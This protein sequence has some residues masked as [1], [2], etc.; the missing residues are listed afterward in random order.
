M[1][2]SRLTIVNKCVA[3]A[4]LRRRQSSAM[5]RVVLRGSRTPGRV[6][7]PRRVVRNRALITRS[8]RC[9]P[10]RC[11]LMLMAAT[12]RKLEWARHKTKRLCAFI[13]LRAGCKLQLLQLR[14]ERRQT[15]VYADW[16]EHIIARPCAMNTVDARKPADW[17]SEWKSNTYKKETRDQ[18]WN[19]LK[20]RFCMH[21]ARRDP[22]TRECRGKSSWPWFIRD[23]IVVLS[24]TVFRLF[25]F[26]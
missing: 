1:A 25:L 18:T 11:G 2:S 6:T 26:H 9:A 5:R 8:R 19:R 24:F 4:Q 23:S 14:P 20:V 17:Q 16:F 13:L 10:P 3:V 15:M 7:P 12:P 22:D 21:F